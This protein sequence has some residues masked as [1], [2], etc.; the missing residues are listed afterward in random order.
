M[1]PVW[2][3]KPKLTLKPLP[4]RSSTS[5]LVPPE[6]QS[7]AKNCQQ[8]ELTAVG[9]VRRSAGADAA[10]I[11]NFMQWFQAISANMNAEAQKRVQLQLQLGVM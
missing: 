4:A 8:I 11:N 3:I 5:K 10:L 1:S 2:M 7:D 9:N 6:T